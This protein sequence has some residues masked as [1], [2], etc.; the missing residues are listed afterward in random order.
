MG[1]TKENSKE[2][3]RVEPDGSTAAYAGSFA[4]A[5][6]VSEADALAC[7]CRWSG[8]DHEAMKRNRVKAGCPVHGPEGESNE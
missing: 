8:E 2:H 7:R 6:G 4:E 1:P 3:N 5:M